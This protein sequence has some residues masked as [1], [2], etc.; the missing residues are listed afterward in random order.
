[1]SPEIVQRKAYYGPPTD[2][3]ATGI[4]FYAM[5]CGRFPFKGSDTKDLYKTIARGHYTFTDN[6]QIISN[7]SKV[8]LMKL[9]AVNPNHRNSAS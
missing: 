4:L 8:F 3:W 2:I 9:L 7:E 1:M 5:L 6:S